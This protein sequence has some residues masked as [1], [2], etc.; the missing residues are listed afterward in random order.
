MSKYNFKKIEKKWQDKWDKSGI[1]KAKDFSLKEKFYCMIEFPYPSGAGLHVGHVR[2][3]TAMDVVCRKKRMQGKNVLY[4]IGW[5]AFGLPTENF[6]I[7]TKKHPTVVTRENIAKFKKQIKSYG[8]SFDWSREINTTD[9]EYYKWTQWIFLKLYN[10]FYDDKLNK[11]RLIEELKIPKGLNALERKNFI[12]DHRMA[13]EKEMPINWCPSCKIGLANEE[14]IAGNCERCGAIAEKKNV[15]QWMLRIT[16]YSERLICDLDTV[17]YLDKIKTQQVNW[18]GKSEGAEIDFA[19]KSEKVKETN[20]QLRVFTT[21]PDTIFGVSY[22]V[23]APEHPAIE[24][25]KNEI[26]N[27]NE[28]Q[29]YIEDAKNKSDLDRTDLSKEKSGVELRGIKAINPVSEEEIPVWTSDYV[30]SSYGTGAIMAVPAHDMR[31]MEFALKFDLPIKSVIEPEGGRTA[32]FIHGFEDDENGQFSPWKDGDIKEKLEALGYEIIAPNMP[33]SHHP[34]R[35][36]WLTFLKQFEHKINSNTIMIGHSLGCI[37]VADFI[38]YTGKKIK[39]AYLVA[40]ASET[41]DFVRFNKEWRNENSDIAAVEKFANEKTDWNGIKNKTEIIKIILSDNDKYIPFTETKRFFEE[42]KIACITLH[43]QKHF[44]GR[45]IPELYREIA[46][47][48]YVEEGIAINSHEW[49]RVSTLEFKKKILQYISKNKL[50]TKSVNYKLRDWVFSRQHY[51]GEP[52]P[53]I[54]CKHCLA[55]TL[56]VKVEVSFPK[57]KVFKLITSGQ[58]TVDTRALNPE[59]PDRYF[60]N[61]KVGDFVKFNDK[62][63]NDFAIVKITKVQT[64][65][66]LGELF[67][68]KNLLKKIFPDFQDSHDYK[69]LEKKYSFTKNYVQRINKNGLIAWEFELLDTTVKIPLSEKELPLKLPDVKNYEPTDTGESPLAGISKWTEI[70]C[71]VCGQPA[72][73]ET[74]TM[75]NW[76][77]SSWYFLRYIDSKNKKTFADRKKLDYWMPVNLYNGGMEHTTL[78]LLYSRFWHKFLFDLGYVGTSEPYYSR[79]SHGMIIAEDGQKMSKSRGNVVNPD[80]IIKN[81][82]AD[83]L[84]VYE[85]FMGPYSEAIA[86]N[87]N[88]LIGVNRFLERVWNLQN[89]VNIETGKQKILIAT[90][91]P[92][93]LKELKAGLKDFEVIGLNNLKIKYPEPRENG[94]TFEENSLLKAKY[95]AKKTGFVTI[96]DDSG[97]CIK[98]MNNMPGVQSSRFAKGNYPAAYAK[99]FKEIEGKDRSAFFK[100]SVTI[101]NPKNDSYQQFDGICEGSIAEKPQGKNGFGYDP[102]FIPEGL[103][104][105]FGDCKLKEKN[106][107]D[108]RAKALAKLKNYLANEI[109][110]EEEIESIAHKTIKK[111]TEDIDELKFN[112]CIAQLMI[113]AN[114]LEKRDQILK[115]NFEIFIALL[116]PFAPHIT[117]EIW[118]NLGNKKSVHLNVW[119]TFDPKLIHDKEIELVVQVNGKVRDKIK[120]SADISEEE[121]RQTALS[122]EKVIRWFEGREPK[123]VIVIKGKLVS[124][125][126]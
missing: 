71:P 100:A 86:W 99:I 88:S 108:H 109:K 82:G 81:Y 19:I 61:V 98:A 18:I 15:R 25:Y 104:K 56:D 114:A 72:R 31:D 102:I 11:A 51:W 64:F 24:K 7:K 27:W 126:L 40:P 4:P 45:R 96:A 124:I 12:D 95:Y 2:S 47:D 55:D 57:E 115:K 75:P 10:S 83:T 84:R 76:A 107:Y 120:V 121:A 20:E 53:I 93:K 22:M 29:Q 59:E 65:N 21:R 78:H 44:I 26:S 110:N 52:I 118:Q 80:D 13:Y 37:T 30:L 48:S 122:S 3:H 9:P 23:V 42:K 6:A 123:K 33:N 63:N 91:N 54:K 125:V 17:D 113:F 41:V 49:N 68:D 36:E 69:S 90:N 16:K 74:D 116:S 89:K 112:T 79:R 105:T 8:P 97:L 111:I 67:E 60:G 70:K 1:Y 62:Q 14:V 87:T 38:N 50:G 117:E 34:D 119:P 77:G 103:N 92:G 43:E 94:K 58:K 73:R 5:D 39:A 46:L 32:F 66:N 85:M 106:E 28:V 101:Y 35:A